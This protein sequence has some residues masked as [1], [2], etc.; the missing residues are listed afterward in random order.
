MSMQDG[1]Q[2]HHTYTQRHA[3]IRG[4]ASGSFVECVCVCA[5]GRVGD[6]SHAAFD[7]DG[8][9]RE[10]LVATPAPFLIVAAPHSFSFSLSDS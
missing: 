10:R 2:V 8:R 1:S 4:S 7:G 3:R 6:S 9:D 5:S